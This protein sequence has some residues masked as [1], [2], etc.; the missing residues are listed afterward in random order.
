MSNDCEHLFFCNEGEAIE[1]LN[2]EGIHCHV[3]FAIELETLQKW[4]D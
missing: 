2:I 4:Q 1:T 3:I